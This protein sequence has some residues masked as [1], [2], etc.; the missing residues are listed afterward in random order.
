MAAIAAVAPVIEDAVVTG[1]DRDEVG[2][3]VFPSLAGCRGLC[4][5][6]APMRRSRRSSREPAVRENAGGGSRP[7]QCRG[8]RQLPSHRPRAVPGGSALASTSEITDKGYLNQR[9][10]LERR[11][12]WVAR[13][14]AAPADPAVIL[15]E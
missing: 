1:H 4:P 7:L 14:Y 5:H 10:V 6:V 2:L 12:D 3:L 11:A 13:L 9:A 8:R 15:P